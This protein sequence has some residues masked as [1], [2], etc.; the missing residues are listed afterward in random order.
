MPFKNNLVNMWWPIKERIIEFIT[1]NVCIKLILLLNKSKSEVLATHLNNMAAGYARRPKE[2]CWD[3]NNSNS[4][5]KH[6][7]ITV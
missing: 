3:C 4:C 2:Y 7:T 1:Y 6:K 5:P